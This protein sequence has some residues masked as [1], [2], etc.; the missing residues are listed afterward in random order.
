[1][2]HEISPAAPLPDL[3]DLRAKLGAAWTQVLPDVPL[4]LPVYF[5][6]FD[7][8]V[9]RGADLGVGKARGEWAVVHV[10]ANQ[11]ITVSNGPFDHMEQ[12]VAALIAQVAGN[13]AITFLGSLP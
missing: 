4:F 1:M 6:D 12:A 8:L 10:H 13:R 3:T 7:G 2:S 11:A 5:D 9:V